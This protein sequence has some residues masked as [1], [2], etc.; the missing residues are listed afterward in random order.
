M[1]LSALQQFSADCQMAAVAM[2]TFKVVAGT[3]PAIFSVA[4]PPAIATEENRVL[5]RIECTGFH[6]NNLR[7][8]KSWGKGLT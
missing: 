8:L 5:P 3:N 7:Q 6:W 4:Q 1:I 2:A